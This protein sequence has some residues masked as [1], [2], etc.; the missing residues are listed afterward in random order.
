MTIAKLKFQAWIIK[1]NIFVR[2][3]ADLLDYLLVMHLA[4]AADAPVLS[5]LWKFF[6]FCTA[7]SRPLLALH[8]GCNE[9][10]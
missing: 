8:S 1:A 7:A 5:A 9:L 6:C 2:S 10:N 4:P 3:A